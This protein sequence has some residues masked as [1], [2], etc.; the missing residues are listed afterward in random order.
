MRL[1]DWPSLRL[2]IPLIAGI[3][4]SDTILNTRAEVPV[5]CALAVIPVLV[6][7]TIICSDR[8]PLFSGLCLSLCFFFAG[9][10]LYGIQ[11]NRVRVEWPERWVVY[12]G[13]VNTY[14]V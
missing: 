3:I 7:L 11:L 8:R 4:I 9:A 2:V 1:Q 14:P 12:H 5:W 6:L 10:F 13:T